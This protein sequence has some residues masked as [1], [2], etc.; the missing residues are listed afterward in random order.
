MLSLLHC[1]KFGVEGLRTR[2]RVFVMTVISINDSSH[3][4]PPPHHHTPPYPP[5]PT[6]PPSH[7]TPPHTEDQQFNDE[8]SYLIKQI[9]EM[10]PQ[11]S[12][13][14]GAGI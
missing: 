1:V 5:H 4:T 6:P 12:Q 10:V 2:G 14:D 11:S 9:K 8:K 13:S 7:T 3:T